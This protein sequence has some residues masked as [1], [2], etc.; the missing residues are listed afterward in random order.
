MAQQPT[1]SAP[2]PAPAPGPT[3]LQTL[4]KAVA[5]EVNVEQSAIKLINGLSKEVNDMASE[6]KSSGSGSI[7][8]SDLQALAK[9]LNDSSKALAAAVTANTPASASGSGSTSGSSSS[10]SSSTGSGQPQH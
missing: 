5:N 2:L 7:P 8:A 10:G 9:Q 1:S 3:D 6:A 4:Q